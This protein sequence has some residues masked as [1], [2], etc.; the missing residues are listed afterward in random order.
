MHLVLNFCMITLKFFPHFNEQVVTMQF[1]CRVCRDMIIFCEVP[2]RHSDFSQ[3][4]LE[5]YILLFENRRFI[6]INV[7]IIAFVLQDIVDRLKDEDYVMFPIFKESDSKS[8]AYYLY[9][10]T[11]V[12]RHRSQSQFGCVNR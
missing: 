2:L 8:L 11:S 6:F 7:C 3:I 12:N 5:E 9:A 4:H 1:F 10:P